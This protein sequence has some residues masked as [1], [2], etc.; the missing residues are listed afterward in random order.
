MNITIL[1]KN[2]E[3][4]EPLKIY[5]EE[6]TAHLEKIQQQI[7]ACRIDISRDTH[8]HKGDIFRVEINLN[9]PHKLLRAVEFRPDAREAIDI[10]V[11]K[12]ARQVREYKGKKLS[13]RR[14]ARLFKL[15]K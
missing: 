7:L 11:D 13:L 15:G 2:V 6:K 4:T 14:F 8:H 5:I 10:C 12:I 9:I 1:G 3:V